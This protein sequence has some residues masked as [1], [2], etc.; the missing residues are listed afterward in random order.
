M[1]FHQVEE[2]QLKSNEIS[3]NT[4]TTSTTA[5]EVLVLQAESSEKLSAQLDSTDINQQELDLTTIKKNPY[6]QEEEEEFFR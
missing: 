5:Q 3:Q 1:Y 4:A 6:S 2:F